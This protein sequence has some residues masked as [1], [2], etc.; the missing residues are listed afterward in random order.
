MN[1]ENDM[2]DHEPT[3]QE[4]RDERTEKVRRFQHDNRRSVRMHAILSAKP[5]PKRRGG[6][7]A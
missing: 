7:R 1:M 4:R 2:D 6:R 5:K 3:R